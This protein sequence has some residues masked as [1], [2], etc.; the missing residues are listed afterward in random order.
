MN[1]E[2]REKFNKEK[3]KEAILYLIAKSPGH[4]LKG[5]KKLAK[6]LYF[7][8]FNFFEA[9]EEPLT[10]AT[11]R[12]LPMGPVPDELECALKEM[13]GEEIKIS[14]KQIGL[15]NDVWVFNLNQKS[16]E[17]NF[18]LISDKEKLVLDKVYKDFGG[19]DGNTLEAISHT[20]APYNA[21]TRGERI[22]YELSFY[23]DKSLAELIG[24]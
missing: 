15:K 23:R 8:D 1:E 22:P 14:K 5:K 18:N 9:Y 21:V 4:T 6:L 2:K 7:S 11:Y 12:A 24:E 17:L 13:N 16:D 20:E 10:G 3:F 19:L